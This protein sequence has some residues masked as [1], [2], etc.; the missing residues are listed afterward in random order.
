M[1]RTI[2]LLIIGFVLLI[3]GADFLVNGASAIARKFHIPEMIIGL[4]IVAFGTS[5]PEL[6]VNIQAAFAGST[7]IA[8]S[9]VLGSNIS[10]ILLIIGITSII[11]PLPIH[12]NT[13]TVDIPFMTL[14]LI[15]FSLLVASPF[16]GEMTGVLDRS[17]AL[18][19]LL[20]FGIFI[21]Y[22]FFD[23]VV[24]E[25][26]I[27]THS[28]TMWKSLLFIVLGLVGLTFG[29]DMIVDSAQ[30]LAISR[31]MSERLIGLT[32]VALGTSLPELATSVTAV[33]KGKTDLAIG[34]VV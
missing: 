32:V 31:G 26:D 21:Y 29:G 1:L 14:I 3:K 5:L 13:R 15:V 22:L 25:A 18:I 19:L 10:N 16:A 4:T 11:V 28:Y 24:E 12:R 6:V 7:D 34:N 23:A 20:V 33:L 30:K 2:I 17:G 9:N 8:I 27:E